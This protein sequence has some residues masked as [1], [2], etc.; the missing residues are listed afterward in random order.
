[1]RVRARR[2]DRRGVPVMYRGRAVA[3]V[4]AAMLSLAAASVQAQP[5]L[6]DK[7][8][9]SILN[10]ISEVNANGSYRIDNIPVPVG[11]TRVRIICEQNGVT[12]RGQSAFKRLIPNTYTSF[13]PISFADDDPIP[14]AITITSTA[15]VLTPQAFGAQLV[16]TGVLVDG[17]QADF[18]LSESGTSY[19]SSNTAIATVSQNGFVTAISSG[20][21]LITATNEG[22]IA[23]F[24]MQVQLET[25]AD[26][27]DIPDDFEADNATN[28]G[29]ANLARL[30]GVTVT[31][32]S[33]F[34]GKPASRVLDG[35]L[36]TSWFTQ[37][38]DAANLRTT[39][40][41]ELALPS[42]I[43][44]AQIR[45]TGNRESP[46]GFD[47]LA[48]F[49]YA[50]DAAGNVLFASPELPLAGPTRDLA[51]PVD[52]DGV[53]RVRF[54]A[55]QDEGSQA[56]LSEFQLISRPGGDGLDAADPADA[57]LDFD[58]DG[59]TN[60]QE[61]ERGTSLFSL[62][63]DG[64]GLGDAAEAPLGTNP[65]LADSD[66]DLLLDGDEISPTADTDNDGI[67][68][69]LDR[70]SDG[71]GLPDGNEVQMGT[72]PTSVDSNNNGIPDG[73]EDFDGDG[74]PN[75]EEVQ[76]H[77]NP[78]DSDSDDDG[79][80]DGEEVLAGDDGFVTQLLRADTDRDGMKDGFETRYGLDPT[81]PNDAIGD[82]DGDGLSNTEEASVGSD[83]FNPDVTPPEVAEVQPANAAIGFATNGNVIVRFTEPLQLGSVSNASI[84]IY[85]E[86]ESSKPQPADA[87]APQ[88][89]T[90][91]SDRLSVT[92]NP[93]LDLTA[94]LGYRVFIQTVRDDAGN[95]FL[96]YLETRFTTGA[97]VDT[98][99]PTVVRV[100][101]VYGATSVP[102]NAP[103]TIEFSEPMDPAT[104]TPDTVQVTD[105]TS[106]LR[107][108]GIV[109]VEANGR[110]ASFVPLAPYGVSRSHSVALTNAIKDRAGN[111]LAY[112]Y[113]YF[114]TGF[115]SDIERP[116][117]VQTSPPDG[118][119]NVPLNALVTLGFDE[120]ISSLG[121][122]EGVLVA[123]GGVPI[124]GGIALSDGNRRITFT[125]AVALPTNTDIDV[126]LTTDVTD[127]AG[128][129]L[130]NAG[131][132]RFRTGQT[133]DLSAPSV[134]THNPV[135]GATNVP[136]NARIVMRFSE[137]INPASVNAT[138]FTLYDGTNGH[139]VTG[140]VA[141]TQNRLTASFTPSEP[142]PPFASFSWYLNG[143]IDPAGQAVPYTAR[144]FTTGGA[145]DGNAPDVLQ[146]SPPDAATGVPVNTLVM[147][148]F[149]EALD[150]LSVGAGSLRVFDDGVPVAGVVSLS[151]TLRTITFTPAAALFAETPYEVEL[152]GVTDV[153]G[154]AALPFASAF[155]TAGLPGGNLGR[156]LDTGE[157]A[158]SVYSVSYPASNGVDGRLDTFW[159]TANG[160]AANLGDSPFWEQSFPG[161]VRIDE[162]R[163]FGRDPGY[164][165]FAGRFELF[166]A[167]G[168]ELFDSGT[169]NFA[170]PN[171]DAVVA[172][173][174]IEGVRRLRFTSQLDE[175]A[176]PCFAELQ[177]IGA[178]DDPRLGRFV[179]TIAPTLTATV[180]INGATGV[181]QNA[182]IAMTF[183]EPLA[184]TSVNSGSIQVTVDGF[185][186]LLPG[187]VN[188]NGANVTFTPSSPLPPGRVI[189][190]YLY[191]SIE[192]LAGN[193][194]GSTSFA[195]TAGAVADA[196]P[197]A[198][199]SITPVN[200]AA[201]VGRTTPIVLFFSE[202]LDA[203]TV[204][205]DSFALFGNGV[206][207]GKS[208]ARSADNTAI[209]L[210]TT[211]P[212]TTQI[213]VVATNDV[214]DLA[215]NRLVS[216]Q[217]VFNT[218]TVLDIGA[219]TVVTIRPGNGAT[220][221]PLDSTVVLYASEPL[222]PN[223]IDAGF[224]VAE[225]GVLVPGALDL[226]D[227][228]TTI[229][230][231][232]NAPFIANALIQV[233]AT[234]QLLDLEGNAL[235]NYQASFRVVPNPAV[236]A[237][238]AEAS[239]PV[240]GATN[241]P[242]N[243]AI[244]VRFSEPLKAS[245][246][247]AAS[248]R[249]YPSG[250]PE[251]G[252]A[253]SLI[254]GGRVIRFV[255]TSALAA[256][257][258]HSLQI[259]GVQG[260]DDGTVSFYSASFT[261]GAG[262]DAVAP[263]VL[264]ISPPDGAV[265]VGV[266]AVIRVRFSEAVNPLTINANTIA[267]S[268]PDGVLLAASIRFENGNR[269]VAIDP[270]GPLA[271]GALHDVVV[272]G[273]R[274]VAGNL[275]LAASASFTTR[276][277]ADTRLPTVSR[278]TPTSG[279]IGVPLNG[280]LVAEFD[281]PIDPGSIATAAI[282]VT[283][284]NFTALPLTITA[285]A[286]GRSVIIVPTGLA[287]NQGHTWS[288]SGIRDVTGNDMSYF[289]ITFTTGVQSDASG[290]HVLRVSPSSGFGG[291]PTNVRMAIEFDEPVS[292]TALA[293]V[294]L[295]R[296]GT[297]I[298]TTITLS[299]GNRIANF[300]PL[301]PLAPSA[302]HTLRIAAVS[303]FAGN[304][305]A[306][307]FQS[308]FTTGA[309]ADLIATAPGASNPINGAIGVATN[310]VIKVLFPERVN[311]LT[312]N[313]TTFTLYDY[314]L[315]VYRSGT[316][317]V[318]PDGLSATFTPDEPMS[319][320]TSHYWYLNGAT[321]LAG[322]TFGY[323]QRN[324][325]TGSGVDLDPPAVSAVVPASGGTNLPANTLIA[326]DVDEPVD[327]LSLGANAMRVLD[328]VTP[329]AGTFA[330]AP[331]LRR[332]SFAPTLPLA[333]G[334]TYQ[335]QAS[336]FKDVAGNAVAPFVSSFTTSSAQ[337]G[338]LAQTLGA[339]ESASSSYSA[340]YPP[341]NSVDGRL[342]TYWCTAVGEAANLGD[343]PYWEQLLPGD[344]T[345]SEIRFFGRV[346]NYNFIA[347]RFELFSAGGAVLFD[348]GTVNFAPPNRDAVVAT[349]GV[350][351]VRRI[352]FTSLLDESQQPCFSEIEVVGNYANPRLAQLSDLRAPTIVS[353]S[354]L[355]GATA[356][357]VN[358]SIAAVI[359]EA[360]NPLSL[361]A[362]SFQ[363]AIDGI[364]GILPGALSI[365][366]TTVTF[367]PQTPLPPNKTVRAYLTA[368]LEDLAGND[369][370]YTNWVFTTG[371]TADVT[372]P[373]VLGVTPLGGAAD[374]GRN[375]PIVLVFSEPIDPITITD[376]TFL[377][378]AN[379]VE[380]TKSLTRSSDNSTV[381]LSATWPADVEIAVV[382]TNDVKDLAGN[383]LADFESLF[384]TGV[385]EDVGRPSIVSQRP[386]SGA[387]RVATN[388]TIV[389]YA[390]EP[391]D[392]A[393]VATGIV[394]TQNG[395]QIAG[396][397]TVSA[398][399]TSFEFTPNAALIRNALIQVS[400]D[401]SITDLEANALNVFQS[402]FRVLPD[403]STEAAF[404]ESA[405]PRNGALAV[406]RNSVLE[407]RFSEPLAASSINTSTVRLYPSG[408]PEAAGT[409]TLL[410]GGRL[411]RF[412]PSAPLASSLSHTWQVS[413]AT[414]VDGG[415]V[416]Y[417][418][419]SF[420]TSAASDA[421][422]PTVTS[423]A[424]PHD[425]VDVGVNARVI[426]RFSEAV[427][428]MTVTGDNVAL[429]GPGGAIQPCTISFADGDRTALIEPHGPLA[430]NAL[431][432]IFVSGVR[433][434][435]GNLVVPNSASFTTRSGADTSAPT[436]ARYAPSNGA[437]AIPT[438]AQLRFTFNEPID[439]GSVAPGTIQLYPSGLAAVPG[440]AIVGADGRS[441]AFT[442]TVP[443]A[444][445]L[446]H[447]WYLSGIRD[448]SGNENVY[449]GLSFTT[450]AGPDVAA[451]T[452][453][454]V[455]PANGALAVPTNVRIAIETS[456]P[457][458][459]A[460]LAGIV[461]RVGGTPVATSA[462]LS[463]NARIVYLQ[464]LL[465][466][467]PNTL[468]A[469]TIAGVRDLAGNVL[470]SAVVSGFTTGSGA[471]STPGS[472][473]TW[474]PGP[475]ATGISTA[476]VVTLHF[477]ERVDPTSVNATTFT[478]LDSN[479]G[480]YRA[481]SV[482][483]A[484]DGLSATFTPAATLRPSVP[485]YWYLSGATD[486]AGQPFNY[487]S[488][489]FTTGTGP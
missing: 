401:A 183:S 404:A 414:G 300:A 252:G 213:A 286:D 237:A 339:T 396:S 56:G 125:S 245:T 363:I 181:A 364:T 243:A 469:L 461:L 122:A 434:V 223:S 166:D 73:T 424:P 444:A 134:L 20:N 427:N 150:V 162:I 210:T 310:T 358:A 58:L 84:S 482:V 57:A 377:L 206:E 386:A 226:G 352:R 257:R 63:T 142:L 320:F 214:R 11:A 156:T 410:D 398:G 14:V 294:T 332:V 399:G 83:P 407:A 315:N 452:V 287:A 172:T 356:V 413:G 215:G 68:N 311:P 52:L 468:H 481:G 432:E 406:P 205:D 199:V 138:S 423:I 402:S 111:A 437:T 479:I 285:G 163:F 9:A 78:L 323:V 279:A 435:A 438:N 102:T 341:S 477:S 326:I 430:E 340:S 281:E 312:V 445:N 232:P 118:A 274:D 103:F 114:T 74:L 389:F 350:A 455:S 270:Q 314:L 459:G 216:F 88:S 375:T 419:T 37:V 198:V 487:S 47:F 258:A 380:L 273:V 129:P 28:P 165:F 478:L 157:S 351:G 408:L 292:A 428:S 152:S 43:A 264:A 472:V 475:V 185:S 204:N 120:P 42:D 333:A 458:S 337:G 470:A 5:V 217:S 209:T 106:G 124:V 77:S 179:D 41:I 148:E 94:F 29:G 305:M 153:A 45:V 456:E 338:S 31:A 307:A 330:I 66:G 392:A 379:G 113:Y 62:D 188:L 3:L 412:T 202:P 133:P 362:T 321:D 449:S 30:P 422:A 278:S 116:Q 100:N 60:K 382:I 167:D 381:T 289:A 319:P 64:D 86:S 349:G 361:D 277:G 151:A 15:T 136:T 420:T 224:F 131:A 40:F 309:G 44:L 365:A 308:T 299:S 155:T 360:V 429:A 372:A 290:P 119:V 483:V 269:I 96:G 87:V 212:P 453:L 32:S 50:Y 128:L 355:N 457:V 426:V 467:A 463:T 81:N 370:P 259:N 26:G 126:T 110:F 345:I 177:T 436:I 304:A 451:P 474:T 297:P 291:V 203:N 383:R 101:P 97:F 409:V 208:I 80:F 197:P 334:V 431:H 296:G 107:V 246:V 441:V 329:I 90:L 49:F 141:V 265:D 112:S 394:V 433:D 272:S 385:T 343:V 98:V 327:A 170:P 2:R 59:L 71:D 186:G 276:V 390:S 53:R 344:A 486:L 27:D 187:T 331:N 149:D 262:A 61:Y 263:A 353:T 33:A 387:T 485:H 85:R 175:S 130:D 65:L 366:G 395:V 22:V 248:V 105:G 69:A 144:S 117:L 266:N 460:D 54:A 376:N 139:Y 425:A 440:T 158:S 192:D 303:D 244:D 443:L 418:G 480:Q 347:G 397:T 201:A 121:L 82:P 48:G 348:S 249:L 471:D 373:S 115:E 250:L 393:T 6:D 180:P 55:T 284:S 271:E 316:V 219:P 195:F 368:P 164:N 465:P 335:I 346:L 240:N 196:T 109:Q 222:D 76:E 464:P 137:A 447:S 476:T 448:V 325:T 16:T 140:V 417:F 178:Y 251:A 21:V 421:A 160:E 127:L 95:P 488:H 446:Y 92:F 403:P 280:V 415:A 400:V 233:F 174:G 108:A 275:A 462:S 328:G 91:S 70:D 342:D 313:T 171:R 154:N 301:L 371:A 19:L 322:Q 51:V 489:Y 283:P 193:D 357:A 191:A 293:G 173:G 391:L 227:G 317:S 1:M 18:T 288:I 268:G 123:A 17:T 384:R 454:R 306:T 261:T 8:R 253:I 39:P 182:A 228:G 218:G 318:P 190:L 36:Q 220:R 143:A 235:S 255:P 466:I 35:S 359:S 194:F 324:L 168:D 231:T 13:G 79:I 473:P 442:P 189:R 229:E 411:V 221:V 24:M 230:F 93:A 12:Y 260:A 200:G 25:D 239:N 38:G 238:F 169:V 450:G 369:I 256:T 367:T 104:L 89:V 336:G 388:T 439:P 405:N 207:L 416:N 159:C 374:V 211:L 132:F 161:D 72:S 234:P 146:V 184:P 99:V 67:K 10:R 378:F 135:N 295:T 7:C 354:P 176:N 267:L 241:V 254:D 145:T 75:Y 282:A 236:E 23:T 302:L 298:A 4:L 46:N 34:S 147:I 247:N 242:T 484:A 225:N